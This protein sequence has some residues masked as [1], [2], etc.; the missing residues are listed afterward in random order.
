ML[1]F[2]INAKL[3]D[4]F[5]ALCAVTVLVSFNILAVIGYVRVFVFGLESILLP[6][7]YTVLIAVSVGVGFYFM[8]LFRGRY[9]EEYECFKT[10]I[11]NGPKG[12][13]RTR[14]YIILTVLLLAVLAII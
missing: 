13:F 10:S 8:F 2:K 12:T 1:F 5:S 4:E 14:A 11:L 3:K 7:C 9:R 6:R